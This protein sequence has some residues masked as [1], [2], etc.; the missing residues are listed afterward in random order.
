M[1]KVRSDWLREH[2]KKYTQWSPVVEKLIENNCFIVIPAIK[3]QKLGRAKLGNLLVI[4]PGIKGR[5]A[6]YR[7]QDGMVICVN[8]AGS[9]SP[10]SVGD[11][12]VYVTEL[13]ASIEPDNSWIEGI[14][15]Q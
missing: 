6:E 10:I 9:H 3:E 8:Y 2:A 11:W 13:A 5:P 15:S 1:Y 7:I 4:E 14:L 12:I